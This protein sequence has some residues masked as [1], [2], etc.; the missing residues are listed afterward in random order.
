VQ[1]CHDIEAGVRIRQPFGVPLVE[2]RRERFGLC[3]L[4]SGANRIFRNVDAGH[5]D[6]APR[7]DQR[8]LARPAG[9]VEQ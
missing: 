9:H 6:A 4:A 5:A 8:E 3:A 1:T 7:G 2:L